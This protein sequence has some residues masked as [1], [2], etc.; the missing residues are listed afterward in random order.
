M[1]EVRKE[2]KSLTNII[3]DNISYLQ[4]GQK[5]QTKLKIFLVGLFIFFQYYGQRKLK[6]FWAYYRTEQKIIHI[7]T[8]GAKVLIEEENITIMEWE[9]HKRTM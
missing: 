1:E 9:K 8:L 3:F 6:Q 5:L 7:N 4:L 2:P